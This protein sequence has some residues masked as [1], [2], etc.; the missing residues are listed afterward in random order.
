MSLSA[1]TV[2][3]RI[4]P[5]TLPDGSTKGSCSRAS[6]SASVEALA[7]EELVA[8]ILPALDALAPSVA[9]KSGGTVA[10]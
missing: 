1:T 4:I 5:I 6:I 10:G 2:G 7:Q 8:K 9:E 3:G